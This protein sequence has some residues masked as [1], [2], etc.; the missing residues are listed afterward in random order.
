MDT[1]YVA[2][3]KCDDS[4]K[5]RL[6]C[7][8]NMDKQQE[9]VKLAERSDCS[10]NW[11][12]L[13]AQ[14]FLG[15]MDALILAGSATGTFITGIKLTEEGCDVFVTVLD[16]FAVD[17]KYYFVGLVD[18]DKRF[19]L[20]T[21]EKID[22]ELIVE[23]RS[24]SS[25]ALSVFDTVWTKFLLFKRL[26][27]I[28][29]V[30]NDMGVVL[31]D[32]FALVDMLLSDNIAYFVLAKDDTEKLL[33]V[34]RKGFMLLSNEFYRFKIKGGMVFSY[35]TMMLDGTNKMN[36]LMVTEELQVERN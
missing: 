36:P 31:G 13:F 4:V 17:P 5:E 34:T 14:L 27:N 33:A 19:K 16:N 22:D 3:F 10:I 15:R 7:Y 26:S 30:L 24:F 1:R 28:H 8:I 18:L 6:G 12:G 2:K 35:Y 11:L 21:F 32:D 25:I 29:A 20:I 9:L 23:Y